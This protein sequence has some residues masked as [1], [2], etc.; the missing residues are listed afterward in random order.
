MLSY[1]QGANNTIHSSLWICLPCRSRALARASLPPDTFAQCILSREDNIV[2]LACALNH[3]FHCGYKHRMPLIL[4]HFYKIF[5]EG[6]R[7]VVFLPNRKTK[8]DQYKE[9]QND[10]N[11]NCNCWHYFKTVSHVLPP[12]KYT[13]II[14]A[15]LK[16]NKNKMLIQKLGRRPGMD[17]NQNRRSRFR[18]NRS[19]YSHSQWS[20][21]GYFRTG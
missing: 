4:Y 16:H 9:Q 21:M 2:P 6:N 12:D 20:R 3:S 15:Y 5:P 11:D 7:L 18:Q 8:T 13:Y 17:H 14:Y 1:R 10:I 19:H